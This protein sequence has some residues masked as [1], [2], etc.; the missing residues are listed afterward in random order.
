MIEESVIALPDSSSCTTVAVHAS[1]D[2]GIQQNR[3]AN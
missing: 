1:S 3:Q 2:V